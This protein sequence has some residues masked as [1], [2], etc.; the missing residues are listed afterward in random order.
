MSAT[1]RGAATD[2]LK[3]FPTPAWTVDAVLP[4]LSLA[5][6]IVDAGC[7]AGAIMDR[8]RRACSADAT[9]IGVELQENL[10]LEAASRFVEP[11]VLG[12][13]G[14]VEVP[15]V[16]IVRADFLTWEP[17]YRVDLVVANPPFSRG[18]QFYR[19]A[20]ALTR[21][22][23]GTVALLLR[24]DWLAPRERGDFLEADPPDALIL[25]RRPQFRM[26]LDGK[27]GTDSCEYAWLCWSP[28]RGG[29]WKRLRCP[30]GQRRGK[31]SPGQEVA[32]QASEDLV[33][34][35]SYHGR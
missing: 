14:A 16:Q 12:P 15:H 21:P 35:G 10:A 22:W 17:G 9:L 2:P 1:R 24:L 18:E 3:H 11:R 31:K 30:P 33:R 6:T 23:G 13:T 4:E 27:K 5:G 34:S 20:R 25:E 28:G 29:R 19:H 26:G 7:G 8:V 32:E